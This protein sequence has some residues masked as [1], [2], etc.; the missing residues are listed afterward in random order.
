MVSFYIFEIMIDF[1]SACAATYY[2]V[3]THA[4][5]FEKSSARFV[6]IGRQTARATG[7][8]DRLDISKLPQLN[9]ANNARTIASDF[10]IDFLRR[11]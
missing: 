8:T 3:R 6:D 9:K 2:F 5:L 7:A 10:L 11:I 4:P 1:M